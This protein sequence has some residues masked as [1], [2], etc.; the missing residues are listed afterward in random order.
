V[1]ENADISRGIVE[2]VSTH[3]ITKLVMGAAADKHCSR[4]AAMCSIIFSP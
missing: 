3:G 4:Y 2:L 1:V